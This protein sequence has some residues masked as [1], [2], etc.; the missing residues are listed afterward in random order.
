VSGDVTVETAGNDADMSAA[1]VS[2]D[3][4][5]RAVKAR[6]LDA[7]SVSGGIALTDVTCD[8]VKANSISGDVVFGG[9]L[10]K[11]G[12]YMLQSHSGDVTLH[13]TDKMGFEVNASTF[14]GDI[15]SDLQ[16]VSTF[17]G[18]GGRGEPGRRPKRGPGQRVSGTF[19]DGGAL[20]ELSTFSGNVKIVSTTAAKV[21][22]K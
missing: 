11:G 3:V 12:R 2:G 15:T 5:M 9:P 19:G 4:T 14:S 10:A 20:L 22:K 8:R 1:S 7:N 18:D 21:I 17:G 6:S 16:I 13:V